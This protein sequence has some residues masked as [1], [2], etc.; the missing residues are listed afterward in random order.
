MNGD[1]MENDEEVMKK[2]SIVEP[3]P[4]LRNN[5]MAFGFEVGDGWRPLVIELLDKIQKIVDENPEY[6][7]LKITE[8]KSKYASLRVYLN[9]YFEEIEKL[10][11]EYEKMSIHICEVCGEK[12]KVRNI[13]YWLYCLCN[14]HYKERLDKIKER[15]DKIKE[16]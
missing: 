2:Y 5:L 12:G 15:L 8:I 16:K 4:T 10:I 9:Y 7:E 3:D 13:N 6:S 1:I 14:K 11:D